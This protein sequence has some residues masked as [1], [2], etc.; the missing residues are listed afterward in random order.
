MTSQARSFPA[1][2]PCSRA[3]PEGEPRPLCPARGRGCRAPSVPRGCNEPPRGI[4]DPGPGGAFPPSYPPSQA[5]RASSGARNFC[6]RDRRAFAP[7]KDSEPPGPGPPLPCPGDSLAG[8]GG[9]RGSEP[10]GG[11][12]ELHL[13]TLRRP[14]GPNPG[15]AGRGARPGRFPS[16]P[17][18]PLTSRGHA[19]PRQ[20]AREA[21][22]EGRRRPAGRELSSSGKGRA[23]RQRPPP[24]GGL[25][26]GLEGRRA[27]G[28][29]AVARGVQARNP[30]AAK[31]PASP[32][33]SPKLASA[34]A[35]T[36]SGR[37]DCRAQTARM[38]RTGAAALRQTSRSFRWDRPS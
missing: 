1:P 31:E 7:E 36:P 3:G 25:P 28:G 5:G 37:R 11:Q 15:P 22:R 21:G 9:E 33:P 12:A 27:D 17:P 23:E 6:G 24:P 2:N 4:R 30:P 13:L 16:R 34:E 19:A 18:A 10:A 38:S 8:G 26:R 14:R 35:Q 29:E 20:P 32:P